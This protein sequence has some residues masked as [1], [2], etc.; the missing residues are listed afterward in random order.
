MV[1]KWPNTVADMVIDKCVWNQWWIQ[2]FYEGDAVGSGAEPPVVE[3]E[4][5]VG[6]RR[7]VP[8]RGFGGEALFPEKLSTFC[9]IT[10][11]LIW[12]LVAG[13]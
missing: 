4:P 11:N 9:D 6:S 13:T 8:G 5:P 7:R 2:D 3:A 12:N 1:P 10:N